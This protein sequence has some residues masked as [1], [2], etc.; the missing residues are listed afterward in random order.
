MMV[1]ELGHS[2][3]DFGTHTNSAVDLKPLKEPVHSPRAGAA[4]LDT[5]ILR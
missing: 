3:R 4:A 1:E 5:D 2:V